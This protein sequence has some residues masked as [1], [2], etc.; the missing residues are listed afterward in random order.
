MHAKEGCYVLAMSHRDMG[1][2]G[3][4]VTMEQIKSMSRDDLE[5]DCGFI[6]F[7]LFRNMLKHDTA[8]AITELKGGDTRVV[9]IT[10]DTALTGVFIARQCGMISAHQRV[11][12]G[13]LV[14]GNMV[15]HD[16]DSG[17]YVDVDAVLAD[18]PREEHE[19]QVELAMTGR[20]FEWLCA[21][22]LIRH[23]LLHTRVFARMTPGDKVQCV[24]LHMEKG[25]TAMCGD[26]GND[27][28]ALRAAHVGLALSEAE[29][30][31]VSPFSTGNR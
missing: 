9:M 31:I 25:V 23:Y 18:D 28:G 14:A 15:W 7:V 29:A 2:L 21:Q 19:K 20:A 6:G 30:S 24:Q 3:E 4:D 5:K 13:D 22:G 11:L 16:V 8:D 1:V 12:L 26:G 27:C 17:E 10:G